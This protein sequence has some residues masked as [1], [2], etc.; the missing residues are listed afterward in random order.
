MTLPRRFGGV[1]MGLI[2]LALLGAI[3]TAAQ[4]PATK[5]SSDKEAPP[6]A[7]RTY[8]PSRR[9]PDFFGQLGLTPEQ[10]ESIYTI[11]GKHYDEI[12]ALQKQIAD[13]QAKMLTEC[14]GV[15]TDAQKQ[16]LANR[17]KAAAETKKKAASEKSTS[18]TST[19]T[20]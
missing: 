11:R 9:V 8:N 2:G 7:K 15:L 17:R 12:T 1:G 16:S 4:E 13:I 19:P 6:S 10:K 3:A 20:S 14:E 5:E 18:K